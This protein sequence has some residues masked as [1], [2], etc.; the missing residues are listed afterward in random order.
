MRRAR[1]LAF[2]CLFVGIGALQAHAF[3]LTGTW[4]GK[5]TCRAQINGA[6]STIANDDSVM[7][8]TQL[9]PDGYVDLDNGTYHYSGW[10]AADN[11]NDKRGATTVVD[12][13]TNPRSEF[14]NEMISAKVK[15]P[16]G[17][18]SGE[19]NGTSAYNLAQP[20]NIELGGICRYTFERVS[21]TDPGVLPCPPK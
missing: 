13:D 1:I 21:A 16:S 9:G 3:D 20:G 15:A 14:S 10:A 11:D 4:E 8:I 17:A 5:W 7:K 19:F 18:D 6:P 2:V 12:C